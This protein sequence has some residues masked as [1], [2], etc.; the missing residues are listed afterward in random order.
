MTTRELWKAA[1]IAGASFGAV[2]IGWFAFGRYLDGLSWGQAALIYVTLIVGSQ[3][4]L[5]PRWGR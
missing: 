3:V 1:C 4:L 2:E 5:V